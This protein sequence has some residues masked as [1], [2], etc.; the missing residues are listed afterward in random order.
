MLKIKVPATSANLGPGYDSFGLALN[1]FNKYIFKVNE[2]SKKINIKIINQNNEEVNL[3]KDDNLILKTVDFFKTIFP[4]KVEKNKLSIHVQLRYPLNRG[5]GSS[6]GAI[7]AT[8]VGL[9]NLFKLN[10]NR[11]QIL[12]YALKLEGHPDNIVPTLLGGFTI[13]KVEDTS[14]RYHKF[15]LDNNIKFML[16]IP[17]FSIKTK[18]ARTVIDKQIPIDIVSKNIANAALLTA[19]L[20]KNDIELIK[21][22]ANDFLHQPKRLSLN[23]DLEIFFNKLKDKINCPL[24]LSGSGPTIM[25]I[26]NTNFDKEIETINKLAKR[27]NMKNQIIETSV[28]NQGIILSKEGV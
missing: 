22:G 16:F 17:N 20:I 1:V 4:T 11:S 10:L 27:E 5:L 21:Q 3:N 7:I 14:I 9:N 28:N 19:G 23:K 13:S 6:A 24:V 15:I 2:I 18:D 8:M 25:L 12:N 26:K